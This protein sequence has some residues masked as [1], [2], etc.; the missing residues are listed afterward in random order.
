MPQKLEKMNTRRTESPLICGKF[1]SGK[2]FIELLKS[3]FRTAVVFSTHSFQNQKTVIWNREHSGTS[4][5]FWPKS[6][7]WGSSNSNCH[8]LTAL[9][10]HYSITEPLGGPREYS[11]AIC[12]LFYFDL[13]HSCASQ[14][15]WICNFG[16]TAEWCT[17]HRLWVVPTLFHLSFILR[18]QA[19]NQGQNHV[20]ESHTGAT[21]HSHKM[22]LNLWIDCRNTGWWSL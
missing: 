2:T 5:D 21:L 9:L 18:E 4:R 7:Q 3:P 11:L 17:S 15:I 20:S 16:I 8:R 1:F 19:I 12:S 13:T 10:Q 14:G 6:P 22:L